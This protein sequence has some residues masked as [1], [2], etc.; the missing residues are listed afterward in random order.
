MHSGQCQCGHVGLRAQGAPRAVHFCHCSMCRRAVGNAFATLVWFRT[1]QITWITHEPASWPSSTIA[2]R[3]FCARC[4]TPIYLAY[5]GSVRMA[6]MLGV[7]DRPQDLVPSYHYGVE[8]RL[9]WVD[10]GAGLPAHSTAADPRP[11]D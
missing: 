10:I 8:G 11:K 3:G 7:L 5:D 9:P 2:R 1:A 4:G 6:L